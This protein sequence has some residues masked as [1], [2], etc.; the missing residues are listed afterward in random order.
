MSMSEERILAKEC[1]EGK[2]KAREELYRR[3]SARLLSLCL[4]YS[5]SRA[6]A[7]DCMHDA[8]VRI[9]ESIRKY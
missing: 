3:Y 8:F 5:D 4:R 2:D 1:S 7:E 9:L 6:E